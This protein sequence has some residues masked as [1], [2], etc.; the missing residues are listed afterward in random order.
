MQFIMYNLLCTIYYVQSIMY[1]L[2]CTI[3]YVNFS[4][5]CVSTIYSSKNRTTINVFTVDLFVLLFGCVSIFLYLQYN[6]GYMVSREL[7][8]Y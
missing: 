4:V 3:Y 1:N 2:L 6:Y 7:Y 5:K 8:Y